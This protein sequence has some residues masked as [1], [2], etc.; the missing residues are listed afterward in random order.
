MQVAD[1]E[2]I[3]SGGGCMGKIRPQTVARGLQ[4]FA[5]LMSGAFA[6]GMAWSQTASVV[7]IESFGEPYV[8]P[9]AAA[10]HQARV[11]IYRAQALTP[12]SL[13]EAEQGLSGTRNQIHTV[14]RAALSKECAPEAKMHSSLGESTLIGGDLMWTTFLAIH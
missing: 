11:M 6:A 4:A 7:N 14:S 12:R 13:A 9:A 3:F 1:L 5:C 8:R 2:R 10:L